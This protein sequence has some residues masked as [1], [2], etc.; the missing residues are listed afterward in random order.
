M[1]LNEEL[2]RNRELMGLQEQ[3]DDLGKKR[4]KKPSMPPPPTCHPNG[5]KI[6]SKNCNNSSTAMWGCVT[7]N[8]GVTPEQVPQVG[9]V[10]YGFATQNGNTVYYEIEQVSPADVSLPSPNN[11][12]LPIDSISIGC[13]YDCDLTTYDCTWNG[14]GNAP[15]PDYNTCMTNCA[16]PIP[17]CMDPTANNYD[18]L[19][20]VDDGSC[21]YGIVGCAASNFTDAFP[22]G[23]IPQ[24]TVGYCR[25]CGLLGNNPNQNSIY[26]QGY[27]FQ[28][29]DSS[30]N[31]NFATL[32]DVCIYIDTNSCC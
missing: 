19:A 9:Q 6:L 32:D 18:P 22:A 2:K 12:D 17:G 23:F 1:N 30:P 31:P 14:S 4:K 3:I 29:S 11:P 26:T 24:T 13:G 16:Q 10:V 5:R 15:H 27:G 25:A 7:V 21:S 8:D 28:P 20:T